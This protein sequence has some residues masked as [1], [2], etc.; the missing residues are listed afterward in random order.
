MARCHG[1]PFVVRARWAAWWRDEHTSTLAA[2]ERPLRV[3][4][5]ESYRK[6]RPLGSR[7]NIADIADK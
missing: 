1:E 3:A 4:E 6:V 2:L 7:M 5:P